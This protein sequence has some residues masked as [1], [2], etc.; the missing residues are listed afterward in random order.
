MKRSGVVKYEERKVPEDLKNIQNVFY[1]P[2]DT[3]SPV[4]YF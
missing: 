3:S 4:L 1:Q 2:K